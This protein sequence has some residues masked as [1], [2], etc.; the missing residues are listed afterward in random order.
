[1]SA[2]EKLVE[3]CAQGLGG[4]TKPWMIKRVAKAE[5][6]K[7][8]IL[9]AAQQEIDERTALLKAPLLLGP[10]TLELSTIEAAT[11]NAATR[12]EARI[13]YREERRQL[14]LESIALG[15]ADALAEESDI[16]T[17]PVDD[18]WIARFFS[19]AQE[20]SNQDLQTLWSRLLAREVASPGAVPMRTLEVLKNLSPAEA[21]LFAQLTAMICSNHDS[22]IYFFPAIPSIG[23]HLRILDEA[24]LLGA[25][26][27]WV[28]RSADEAFI[29]KHA[30][31]DLRFA[32]HL[33][34]SK[35][36]LPWTAPMYPLTRAKA[37]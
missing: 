33:E 14:N 25:R 3:V 24:G 11:G 9:A 34:K 23:R 4:L 18:D 17:E 19:A 13:S 27:E 28:S 30:G 32:A 31:L 6:E 16:S 2:L 1:M 21:H 26:G 8:K 20:V 37:S 36:G 10:G 5:A 7:M 29:W 22:S 12:A 15:A 35:I